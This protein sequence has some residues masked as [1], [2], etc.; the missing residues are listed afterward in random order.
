MNTTT[1]PIRRIK[2]SLALTVL[3]L[4]SVTAAQGVAAATPPLPTGR[5]VPQ[6]VQQWADAWNKADA[7]GMAGLFTDDGVYQDFAFEARFQGKVGVAGWVTLTVDAI[8]DARAV[9][10][11]AFQAGDRVAVQWIF[12]GTPR[13]LGGIASTGKSF[14]IPVTSV[15]FLKQNRIQMVAD[16]YNRAEIFQQLGLP[17]DAW[18]LPGK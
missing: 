9:I 4:M 18:A 6:I 14:S 10:L 12:T 13:R 2:T 5:P 8:P 16:Y 1:L 3:T 17:S 11:D 15:F 7:K